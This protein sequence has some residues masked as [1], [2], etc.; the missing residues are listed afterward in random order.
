[1]RRFPAPPRTP[2]PDDF[3]P[4]IAQAEYRIMRKHSAYRDAKDGL[5]NEAALSLVYDLLTDE[6][7]RQLRDITDQKLV[8]IVGVHAEEATGRNKIPLAYAETLG[9][10][11]TQPTDPGIIQAS[12]A[13]HGN[14][15]SIYHR[16]VS[17]PWFDGYVENNENY[18]IVDDTCTAGGTLANLKGFIESNGGVVVAVSVLARKNI[19]DKVY[20]S[21]APG[22]VQRLKYKHR[23]L[24]EFWAEEFGYGLECLTEGEAG[25]LYSAP[26][27]ETIR[28]RLAEARRD[29]NFNGDEG[30]DSAAV[31]SAGGSDDETDENGR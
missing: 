23:A 5:S 8:R 14:A 6:G 22:M 15:P 26:S 24:D 1:M 18:L 31:P 17:Q 25:Q 30:V 10:V 11:L 27:V 4:I 28:N 16:M 20:I 3:P 29:F 21:L 13:N 2:W 9:R 7:V 19:N 12:V